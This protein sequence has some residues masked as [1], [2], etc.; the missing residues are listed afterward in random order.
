MPRSLISFIIPVSYSEWSFG[1]DTAR[2]SRAAE[3]EAV[4]QPCPMSS[5]LIACTTPTSRDA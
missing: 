4:M 2:F 3:R 1:D 5:C